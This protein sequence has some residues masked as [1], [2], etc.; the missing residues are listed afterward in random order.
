MIRV[1]HGLY[2]SGAFTLTCD[3]EISGG[4]FCAVLGPSGAGKSTLLSLLAGFENLEHGRI[5]LDGVDVT[6]LPPNV[7]PVSM[8][9]QDN[10]VF[11]HLTVAQNVSLG[12]SPSLRL[13]LEQKKIVEDALEHVQLSA[14]ANKR[15][16]DISGGERQRVALARVLVRAK[17][18]LLLDEAF[19]ALDPG[20]RQNLMERVVDIAKARGLTVLMVTHQPDEVKAVADHVMFV[21]GGKVHA[22]VVTRKFFASKDPAIATYL[23][24]REP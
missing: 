12:I 8:V 14:L 18:I 10:N 1:E 3:F 24:Q 20:L 2:R 21:A 13:S 4:Q 6:A 9:F 22:P 15:P 19:A 23:G 17:K 5:I 11:P 16:G 7:R